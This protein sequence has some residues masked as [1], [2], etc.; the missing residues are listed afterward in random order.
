[1]ELTNNTGESHTVYLHAEV[2][3]LRHPLLRGLG[4]GEHMVLE[5]ET[6]SFTLPPGRFRPT[7][8][9]TKVVRG[10]EPSDRVF[11]RGVYKVCIQV[12]ETE[13][14][15]R[16]RE[17]CAKYRVRGECRLRQAWIRSEDRQLLTGE[18]TR[19]FSIPSCSEVDMVK[20]DKVFETGAEYGLELPKIVSLSVNGII[21]IWSG[22][23]LRLILVDDQ[24]V[25]HLVFE[26]SYLLGDG[27]YELR[28][29]GEETLNLPGIKPVKLLVNGKNASIE[30]DSLYIQRIGS[31]TT[32]RLFTQD[33]Y[34][35]KQND[36]KINRINKRNRKLGLKWVA[37][38]TGVSDL[39]YRLKRELFNGE[40]PYG[41]L[42]YKGG[43]FQ[44]QRLSTKSTKESNTCFPRE[45]DWRNRH[46]E[47]WMTPVK[48]QW[49][50]Y[51]PET[52]RI[53]CW[54]VEDGPDWC[55]CE[56]CELRAMGS[57]S[58]FARVAAFESI[59]NLYYNQHLDVDLSE[60]FQ[61]CSYTIGLM[62]PCFTNPEDSGLPDEDCS[63]YVAEWTCDPCEDWE[64]RIWRP[65]QCNRD[66][67]GRHP[68][69][70]EEYPNDLKEYLITKGPRKVS[71]PGHALCLVGWGHDELLG[72]YWIMKNSQEPS[73]GENGY[74]LTP[75]YGGEL[76]SMGM[77]YSGVVPPSGS[78]Y[79]VSCV[80]ND[81]DG[82]HNWGVGEKPPT[83]PESSPPEED[84]DDSDPSLGPYDKCYHCVKLPN[85]AE[86]VAT[87]GKN[88]D[89]ILVG[90][91]NPVIAFEGYSSDHA[92]GYAV[93]EEEG[94]SVTYVGD[95][96]AST[97]GRYPC[98]VQSGD[99]IG[100]IYD[101]PGSMRKLRFTHRVDDTWLEPVDVTPIHS[102][103]CS[104]TVDGDG[105][106]HIAYIGETEPGSFFN[107][108]DAYEFATKFNV[109]IKPIA[110]ELIP[111]SIDTFKVLN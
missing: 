109:E 15:E 38:H 57:C 16:I 24:G 31:E 79:E 19:F 37:G 106:I 89:I 64:T 61:F 43:I 8:L 32:K 52:G 34:R 67:Y 2:S 104:A 65:T 48:C 60:Q 40:P 83:C 81:G 103:R 4:L 82:Y 17:T 87:G 49:G 94:W 74:F 111:Q 13:T 99:G 42:Y 98:L 6:N 33:F 110:K 86:D 90:S 35:Y 62:E 11:P 14:G 70:D 101:I 47:N 66:L 96:Q 84:C 45:F 22:G 55:F 39:P 91:N 44:T 54:D 68:S 56:G 12:V 107:Y 93:K 41:Y 53:T 5:A 36:V 50:C 72:E 29:I 23:F 95:E 27:E 46:G 92:I 97:G 26:S 108:E 69:T 80:D 3:K 51:N 28:N 20:I 75:I 59:I 1:M 88:P 10:E 100:I 102:Q 85:L 78:L 58:I 21:R 25:E 77:G 71:I 105:N 7:Q 30:I 63:P 76:S 18:E 73:Y 9:E